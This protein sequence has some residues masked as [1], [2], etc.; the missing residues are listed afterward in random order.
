MDF[1]LV[2]RIPH[3]RT[4]VYETHRDRLPELIL[5][6]GAGKLH[7]IKGDGRSAP[8]FP[9]DVGMPVVA[10]DLA[11]TMDWGVITGYSWERKEFWC[12]TYEDPTG[13]YVVATSWP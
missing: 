8:G 2:D 3:A 4:V 1:T 10:I 9:V 11:G 13:D 7:A 12:R 5:L 6:D